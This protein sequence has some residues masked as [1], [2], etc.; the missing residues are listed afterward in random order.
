MKDFSKI[1]FKWTFRDYVTAVSLYFMIKK[2]SFVSKNSSPEKTAA[3][4]S[5]AVLKALQE[6]KEI[7]SSPKIKVN[8][9]KSS[10]IEALTVSLTGANE[11]ENQVFIK[12]VLELF[13]SIDDPRYVIIGITKIFKTEKRNYA[14]SFSCPSV[15]GVNKESAEIFRKQLKAP[16]GNFELVFTRSENGRK[17][18]NE[19]KKAVVS[20]FN[21][22]NSFYVS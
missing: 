22:I 1:S 4:L 19:C 15:F 2:A 21:T 6:L 20:Q 10:D 13:S 18:L 17:I 12:A 8:V 16:A 7:D 14:N 3:G 5:R 9:K 11:R